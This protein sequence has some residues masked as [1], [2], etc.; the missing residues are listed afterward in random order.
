MQGSDMIY[1]CGVISFLNYKVYDG[2]VIWKVFGKVL[3]LGEYNQ[4]V[5]KLGVQIVR[6]FQK[7]KE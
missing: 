5:Y 4:I 3:S 1:D 7:E 2:F 6:F